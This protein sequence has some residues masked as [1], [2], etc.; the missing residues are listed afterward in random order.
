[1]S[2]SC[3]R[4]CFCIPSTSYLYKKKNK[5]FTK[6]HLILETPFPISFTEKYVLFMS[7]LKRVILI[8]K[9]KKISYNGHRKP[10]LIF[11][12]F[13]L[14]LAIVLLKSWSRLSAINS[15]RLPGQHSREEVPSRSRDLRTLLFIRLPR[16]SGG[17]LGK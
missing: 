10:Y 6:Q 11:Q 7:A 9:Y 2:Q 14:S 3:A 12:N 4:D 16:L 13:S 15:Y 8:W 5:Y 1:M 17:Q